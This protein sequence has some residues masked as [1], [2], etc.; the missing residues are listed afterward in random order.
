MTAGVRAREPGPAP[1]L[2]PVISRRART[3]SRQAASSAT[4]AL[5]LGPTDQPHAPRCPD[6]GGQL[7]SDAPQARPHG[8]MADNANE[9]KNKRKGLDGCAGEDTAGSRVRVSLPGWE[10]P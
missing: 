8:F 5:L 1:G 9:E 4:P 2:R 6:D 7:R 10:S 3:A